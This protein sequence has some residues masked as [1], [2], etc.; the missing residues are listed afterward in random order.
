MKFLLIVAAELI[1]IITV[2]IG[3]LAKDTFCAWVGFAA[4]VAAQVADS[5]T[6]DEVGE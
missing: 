4:L 1:G 2:V 6:Q 5:Y 3:V